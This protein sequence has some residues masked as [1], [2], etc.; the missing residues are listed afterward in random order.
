[1]N[2]KGNKN[3]DGVKQK[4]LSL[5][6][7]HRVFIEGFAGGA[8]IAKNIYTGSETVILIEKNKKQCDILEL[9]LPGSV[10]VND[11][12]F[13][14][15]EN[16]KYI[17]NPNV[18]LFLDPPYIFSTRFNNSIF[19]D[20]EL[21]DNDHVKLLLSILQLPCNVIII[22]PVSSIYAKYLN[23]WYYKNVTI[24][25]NKKNSKEIIYYNFQD[26][27]AKNDYS[28]HGEN[29]TDRQRIKRKITRNIQ[30]IENLNPVDKECLLNAIF[31]KYFNN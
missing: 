18:V 31:M 4:I 19:Y 1:M 21:S 7:K 12:V 3:I 23:F 9:D 29:S 20:F 22:H 17:I 30:K 28:S 11:C 25:Y 14:F 5:I 24:R 16:F 2:Y 26:S 10:V 6:P 15:I 27:I 13:D 8:G